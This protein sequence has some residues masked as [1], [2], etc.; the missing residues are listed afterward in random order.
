METQNFSIRL[1]T[2]IIKKL[3][4]VATKHEWSRNYVIGKFLKEKV[5]ELTG[6]C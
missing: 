2:E 1:N 3:D 4:E 6:E 5:Y